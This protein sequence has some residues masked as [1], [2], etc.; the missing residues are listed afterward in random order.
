MTNAAAVADVKNFDSTQQ[1]SQHQKNK[2]KYDKMEDLKKRQPTMDHVLEKSKF[3]AFQTKLPQLQTVNHTLCHGRT[4][5]AYPQARELDDARPDL[6]EGSHRA[7][8]HWSYTFGWS[9]PRSSIDHVVSM[10]MIKAVKRSVRWSVSL[11]EATDNTNKGYMR[12][13]L[14]TIDRD[15]FSN[16]AWHLKLAQLRG[17]QDA[18]CLLETL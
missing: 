6:K 5:V 17:P 9:I 11:N 16:K 14:F 1:L 8:Q 12:A 15:T 10:D 18:N 7:I 3:I 13:I 4:F 2:L